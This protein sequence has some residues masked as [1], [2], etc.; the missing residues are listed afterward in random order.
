MVRHHS[1]KRFQRVVPVAIRETVH[2][3][4]IVPIAANGVDGIPS[5]AAR[6][7]A[8]I[9][10]RRAGPRHAERSEASG[11]SASIRR[12]LRRCAP[13]NDGSRYRRSAITCARGAQKLRRKTRARPSA[14]A[15]RTGRASRP[16]SAS[17]RGAGISGRFDSAERVTCPLPAGVRSGRQRSALRVLFFVRSYRAAPAEQTAGKR[18][19]RRASVARRLKLGRQRPCYV[20]ADI[21]MLCRRRCACD[22][23]TC[24]VRMVFIDRE[25]S[26][27]QAIRQWRDRRVNPGR[28]VD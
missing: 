4:R 24:K 9:E 15:E 19:D 14:A 17:L 5:P 11:F 27:G 25:L 1:S 21:C 18:K 13:Q 8:A 6:P 26:A 16:P 10:H 2:Q 23:G 20:Q 3:R 28:Y 12:I 22:V 7:S